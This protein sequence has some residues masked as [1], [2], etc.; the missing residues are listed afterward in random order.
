MNICSLPAAAKQIAQGD[1]RASGM[2]LA[3]VQ[4]IQTAFMKI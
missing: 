4:V 1:K 3:M 2:V